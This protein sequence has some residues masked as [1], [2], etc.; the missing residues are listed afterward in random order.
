MAKKGC[1]EMSVTTYQSILHNIKEERRLV[2]TAAEA[3]IHTREN[4]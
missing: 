4:L 1:P 2:Y 3:L